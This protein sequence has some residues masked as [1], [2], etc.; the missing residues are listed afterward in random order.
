ML[1]SHRRAET[2]QVL[3]VNCEQQKRITA[4][5]H[6][7]WLLFPFTCEENIRSHRSRPHLQTVEKA[8]TP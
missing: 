8:Q 6:G 5:N 1:K 4:A 7:P 2:G 3:A